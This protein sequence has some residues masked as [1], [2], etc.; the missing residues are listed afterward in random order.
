MTNNLTYEDFVNLYYGY[1]R[2]RANLHL[3]NIRKRNGDF[4][5]NID[6]DYVAD[7]ATLTTMVTVFEKYDA[8]RGASIKTFI[9]TIVHNEV[10]NELEKESKGAAK[11]ADFDDLKQTIKEMERDDSAEARRSLIPKMMEVIAQLSPD[12]QVIL[13]FYLE[14]KSSYI[15]KSAEKLNISK[16]YVS[17]RRDRI[18]ARLRELMDMTRQQY[19]AYLASYSPSGPFASVLIRG[20]ERRQSH[21]L[22]YMTRKMDRTNPIM[23]SLTVSDL[24]N[25]LVAELL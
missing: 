6:L 16:N 12:D 24:A 8:T 11:K 3:A 23:P 15:E 4:D 13:N 22:Q 7:A 2:D 21:T 18:F 17:V 20:Q 9:N 14:D 5:K 1:A 19:D 10:V 25:K